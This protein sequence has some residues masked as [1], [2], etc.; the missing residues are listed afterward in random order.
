MYEWKKVEEF[1]KYS[2]KGI[3]P[4]YVDKSTIM[5]L[6]QK[7][8]RDNTIDFSF[9]RYTDDTKTISKNK[10]IQV[11]DILFNST[12]QGTAGRCAFVDKIPSDVQL[13]SDSHILLLRC[14]SYY[15]AK[16]LN[17]ALFSFEK[18]IQSFMDG[19]TGQGE[20]D[21]TRLF[22]IQVRIPSELKEQQKIAKILSTL[23]A[24]I[25]LNNR[26]NKE[27]EAMAKTLYDYWFV[28]FDFPHA[29]NKPYK[30]SGGKM[31]YNEEL[32][33]EI[34]E[35]WEVKSLGKYAEIKRGDLITE[36]DTLEG[37]IKVVAA[38]INYSY[39]HSKFN[40]EKNTITISGS[41]A[42]AGH[43]NFWREP[44]FASDCTAIRGKND[45]DTIM[46]LHHLYLLQDYIYS[47]A[48][49]SAQPHVYPEDIKQLHYAIPSESLMDKYKKLILPTNEK[50]AI[51]QQQSQHLIQLRD[52]LLPMLMNGQV[53][54][55]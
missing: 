36:K 30:S 51:N 19:S 47:Q 9:A 31:V 35:G 34:P 53:S 40:R 20:L 55:A 18:E 48:K 46:V 10:I 45:I 44:I 42:N 15:E 14:G 37:H 6:N 27:L 8:I 16:C 3:T 24:K 7:C 29:N 4:S 11:G 32:K 12:G 39:L 25:E 33:R 26:I 2:I 54:V 23:D 17:Y 52:F 5:V 41:G 1:I 13:I 22:N 49:G 50:I 28:Q 38:G 43:I 21:K